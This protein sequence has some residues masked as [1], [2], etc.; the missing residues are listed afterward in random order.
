MELESRL[1]ALC[2]VGGSSL[3]GFW[4]FAQC[5]EGKTRSWQRVSVR[6]VE[7][8]VAVGSGGGASVVW[9]KAGPSQL[10]VWL[11]GAKG[12]LEFLALVCSSLSFKPKRRGFDPWVGKILWGSAWQPTPVFG[13]RSLAGYSPRR[14]RVGHNWSDL[15]HSLGS[16]SSLEQS[17]GSL[18]TSLGP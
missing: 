12:G 14:R 17:F 7:G 15:A 3:T 5:C 11:Q 10:Q 1:G 4:C 16:L 9:S 13:Q 2:L 6:K 8:R 18:C